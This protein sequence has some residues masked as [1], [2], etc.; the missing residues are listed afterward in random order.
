MV[1]LCC[2]IDFLL[3]ESSAD[4]LGLLSSSIMCCEL[5]A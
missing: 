3:M 4:W 5:L 2:I 1:F